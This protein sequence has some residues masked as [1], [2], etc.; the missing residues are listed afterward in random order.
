MVQFASLGVFAIELGVVIRLRGFC[1]LS[2][3]RV[4]GS[5]AN[6]TVGHIKTIAR[7]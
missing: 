2:G 3:G 4:I 5:V 6:N 1:G 7:R